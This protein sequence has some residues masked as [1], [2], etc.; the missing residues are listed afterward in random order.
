[1][2][3]SQTGGGGGG[4]GGDNDTT[5]NCKF[6]SRYLLGLRLTTKHL[7]TGADWLSFLS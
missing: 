3:S 1:M 5:Y 7:A 4:G 6:C 2:F